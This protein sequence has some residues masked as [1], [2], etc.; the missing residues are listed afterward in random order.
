M[1]NKNSGDESEVVLPKG[2][3]FARGVYL[4]IVIGLRNGNT[5]TAT[6]LAVQRKA[7]RIMNAYLERYGECKTIEE[8]ITEVAAVETETNDA[9]VMSG[10]NIKHVSK[11]VKTNI[12]IMIHDISVLRRTVENFVNTTYICLVMLCTWKLIVAWLY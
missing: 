4:G 6:P 12:D 3:H 2:D 9:V 7:R 5:S 8:V 11:A 10:R 1:F